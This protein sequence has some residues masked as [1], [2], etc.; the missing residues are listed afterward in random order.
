MGAGSNLYAKI[1]KFLTRVVRRV[2]GPH[3]GL[4]SPFVREISHTRVPSDAISMVTKTFTFFLAV[5]WSI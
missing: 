1:Q 3:C 5:S 2:D 4:T